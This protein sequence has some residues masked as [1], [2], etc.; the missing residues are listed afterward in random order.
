MKVFKVNG[1]YGVKEGNKI[2]VQPV[3]TSTR[4]MVANDSFS[5]IKL[6]L[7]LKQTKQTLPK[8]NI[9]NSL[10]QNFYGFIAK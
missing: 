1:K 2:I 7:L 6:S 5:P 4:D 8:N 9:K 10:T 3:Y